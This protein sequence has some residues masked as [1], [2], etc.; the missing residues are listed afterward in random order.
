[1]YFFLEPKENEDACKASFFEL[2]TEVHDRRFATKLF[3]KR[4]AFPF[5]INCMPYL[6]SNNKFHA[7]AG[8]EILRIAARAG[9]NRSD[10]YGN[11]C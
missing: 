1:M 3:D 5:Y 10:S 6:H 8:S 9:N 2:S 7:S 11:K 4:D